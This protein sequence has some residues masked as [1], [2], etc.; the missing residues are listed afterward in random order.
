MVKDGQ[1]HLD[2]QPSRWTN[3][4]WRPKAGKKGAKLYE[5]IRSHQTVV[6]RKISRNRAEQIAYYRYLENEQVT[7][8]E[9]VRSLCDHCQQQVSGR[10]IPRYQ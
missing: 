7:L 10:H 1:S 2:S 4:L 9:L 6:I 5:S 3:R 8:G